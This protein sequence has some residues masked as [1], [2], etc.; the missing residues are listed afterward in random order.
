M[1]F[2]ILI[3]L[4]LSSVYAGT[5]VGK[6]ASTAAGNTFKPLGSTGGVNGASTAA[7]NTFKPLGST[8]GVNGAIET[9]KSGMGSVAG[10]VGNVVKNQNVQAGVIGA[11]AGAIGGGIVAANMGNSNEDPVNIIQP[12]D[13]VGSTF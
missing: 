9:A 1:R 8:G 2:T 11:G 7:G 4:V 3:S 12:M 10:G 6:G 5:T 13:S